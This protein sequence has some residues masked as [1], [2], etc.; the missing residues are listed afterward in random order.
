MSTMGASSALARSLPGGKL[1]WAVYVALRSVAERCDAV[2]SGALRCVA[3]RSEVNGITVC[4][5]ACSLQNLPVV[6]LLCLLRIIYLLFVALGHGY[7]P[8]VFDD[9]KAAQLF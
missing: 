6:H 4:L 1:V 8:G 7:L 9:P 5:N 3:E 2:R